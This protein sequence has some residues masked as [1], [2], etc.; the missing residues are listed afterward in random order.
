MGSSNS[1]SVSSPSRSGRKR[2][3]LP[4]LFCGSSVSH[5]PME[6]SDHVDDS[7]TGSPQN[8][9][10]PRHIS[11]SSEQ[12]SSST[13]LL[14]TGLSGFCAETGSNS[15]SAVDTSFTHS[16]SNHSENS[17]LHYQQVNVNDNLMEA[18]RDDKSL[19]ADAPLTSIVGQ[20]TGDVHSDAETIADMS[21]DGNTADFSSDVSGSLV[22]SQPLPRSL[23]SIGE[24][25]QIGMGVLLV[26]VVSIH[27][28]T[29]SS[30]IDEISNREMRRNTRRMFWDAFSR[31]SFRRNSDFPTIVFTTRH[32]D[33]LGS[34]DRWLLDFSGDLHYDGVGRESVVSSTRNDHRSGRQWQS[35]YETPERFHDVHDE[36][37]WQGSSC[38]TGRHP[39]GTCSC[40]SS[41]LGEE[42]SSQANISQSQIFMLADALF[43]VLEEIHHHRMS[44][45][46]SM[47]TLPAPEA[48]VNSF[49]LKNHKVSC[50][51]E[52][53]AH[54]VQQCHICLVDYE[55]GDKIRVL[56]C[57]HEYHMLCVDKWLKEVHGVCPLC[58]DDVCKGVAEGSS[59]NPEIPSL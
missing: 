27:S 18:H 7:S 13:F 41:F 2:R 20:D 42:S 50:K 59:S 6:M 48:V 37:T 40:E 3:L 55:E 19:S 54:D 57:S 47:L 36:Q 23:L 52:N 45:S 5:S 16:F 14:E 25:G 12:Q 21:V 15:D 24:Q 43:E 49:P 38:A 4:S 10:R 26:D 46:L 11:V 32:A 22:D 53:G 9:T 39:R 1:R 51:S 17:E 30:T 31:N 56:P 8:S 33:D 28:N 34:S 58:R 29:L 44:R 35:R